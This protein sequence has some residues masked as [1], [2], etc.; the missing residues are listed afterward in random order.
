M[1]VA[2]TWIGDSIMCMPA[3]QAWRRANPARQL[4]VL[5]KQA[6]AGLWELHRAPDEVI[7]YDATWKA[8]RIA[9]LSVRRRGVARAVIM[10][11]SFRSALVPLWAGVPERIGRRGHWRRFLLTHVVAEPPPGH[12]SLEAYDLMGLPRPPEG[13]EWPALAIGPSDRASASRTIERFARPRLGVLPGAARGPAKRWPADY[14]AVVAARW[15]HETGGSV[16]VMGST[17]DRAAGDRIVH[18]LD[19]GINMAGQTSLVQWAA[20][21]EQCD[22]V[23]G[24]DSGGMHLAAALGRPVV[25]IFGATDPAV[26]GPLGPRV[27]IVAADGPRARSIGRRDAGAEKRLAA[28]RPERVYAALRE[29]AG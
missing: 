15:A 7:A 8:M 10:P 16:I 1:L 6:V 19:E 12:Q 29:L 22:A 27:R 24:N 23:V 26:T 9:A 28:I 5:A 17:A 18:G 20:L 2:P 4:I 3:L 14:F 13:P 11:N 21:I 25:A